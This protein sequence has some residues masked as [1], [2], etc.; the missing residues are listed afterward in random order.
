MTETTDATQT[1]QNQNREAGFASEWIANLL[2]VLDDNLT[3]E[4]RVS[5][6]RNCAE[7]HY[8]SANMDAVVSQYQG[9]PSGFM[10]FLSEKWQW[11]ITYDQAAQT[12]TA[13]ENKPD[14][15][16]P[17]VQKAPGKVSATLCHCS[18]GFA[19]KMFSAVIE[20][21]VEARV[22]RSILRGDKSCV[23]S[24]QVL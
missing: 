5:L 16:C 7:A 6:L 15:V 3:E 10:Q 8:R 11:K 14:C 23:Y 18:E 4:T 24:I 12:I 17:L 20:K 21:P 13:D 22:I 1:Q 9:N 2:T 19:E